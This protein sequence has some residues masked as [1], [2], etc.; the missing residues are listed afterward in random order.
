MRRVDWNCPASWAAC[1]TLSLAKGPLALTVDTLSK[2]TVSVHP[3]EEDD[4]LTLV[5]GIFSRC[6][7]DPFCIL[8]SALSHPFES[9]RGKASFLC[10]PTRRRSSAPFRFLGKTR[11]KGTHVSKLYDET[12]TLDESE[13]DG[14]RYASPG[15]PTSLRGVP[16][17]ARPRGRPRLNRC[18]T[19]LA[20]IRGARGR[21]RL[22]RN[23]SST[24]NG[25][26]IF[27]TNVTLVQTA[28]INMTF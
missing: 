12:E 8:K 5:N 18:H 25:E 10:R 9:V 27:F 17:R 20:T 24:F 19:P 7:F 16:A 13:T 3:L 4:Y 22:S 11:S 6:M 21:P 28:F 14:N 15:L 1:A 23:F 26:D 2:R